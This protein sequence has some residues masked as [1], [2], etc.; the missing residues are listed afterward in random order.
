MTVIAQ[1]QYALK[2]GI[3]IEQAKGFLANYHPTSVD[4]AFARLRTHARTHGGEGHRCGPPRAG[5]HCRSHS[6]R[7]LNSYR[8]PS[9]AREESGG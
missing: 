8:G 5:G 2:S 7:S 6:A 3:V 4:A 9:P 1:L